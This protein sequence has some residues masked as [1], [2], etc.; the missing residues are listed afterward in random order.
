[1]EKAET[2]GVDLIVRAQSEEVTGVFCTK[3]WPSCVKGGQD[4]LKPDQVF[5]SVGVRAGKKVVSK[6]GIPPQGYYV[7]QRRLNASLSHLLCQPRLGCGILTHLIV[8][9][10]AT[11]P[12]LLGLRVLGALYCLTLP[13]FWVPRTWFQRLEGA[14]TKS[15]QLYLARLDS[16]C[17][18]RLGGSCTLTGVWCYYSNCTPKNG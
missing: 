8:L 14:L 16:L 3:R 10:M 5:G 15:H 9:T 12:H 17:Y 6:R 13:G 1:M 7:Q 11:C 2:P 18:E 4:I